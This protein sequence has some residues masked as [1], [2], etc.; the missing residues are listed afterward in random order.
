M[1]KLQ[2]LNRTI[3]FKEP[4]RR[5][6]T[7]QAPSWTHHLYKIRHTRKVAQQL[8]HPHLS[9]PLAKNTV[10]D[11]MKICSFYDQSD[12]SYCLYLHG[13]ASTYM[14]TVPTNIFNRHEIDQTMKYHPHSNIWVHSSSILPTPTISAMIHSRSSYVISFINMMII[15]NRTGHTPLIKKITPF[16]RITTQR[17]TLAIIAVSPL[18]YLCGTNS[19]RI[20]WTIVLT[21]TPTHMT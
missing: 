3:G 14:Y 11:T 9:T 17:W 16:N 18:A 6:I 15:L 1:S 7:H 19:N 21:S 20:W 5:L 10:T 4:T 2:S 12:V 13:V 8:H